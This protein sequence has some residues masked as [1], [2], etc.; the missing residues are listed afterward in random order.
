MRIGYRRV[1]S[2]DQSLDRQL[3][4]ELDVDRVFE[5]KV[6]GSSRNRPALSD[7]IAFARDGDVVVVHSLDRL[8]R[9]LRDLLEIVETLNAKGVAI[10]FVSERLRFSQSDDDPLARLQLHLLS[11]FAQWERAISKR[12]QAE[13]IARAK[14][15]SPQKYKGRRPSIDPNAIRQLKDEG[16]GATEIARRLGVGRASVYRLLAKP[17]ERRK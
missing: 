4:D 15:T 9:D 11:A 16:L 12:R 6:S 2:P 7:L 13:G 14:A 5:E 10:E 3:A 17:S 1:S 8:G